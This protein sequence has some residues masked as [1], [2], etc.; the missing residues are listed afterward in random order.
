M[1]EAIFEFNSRRGL[2]AVRR[3]LDTC[4]WEQSFC[5]LKTG[6]HLVRFVPGG[7]AAIVFRDRFGDLGGTSPGILLASGAAGGVC[8]LTRQNPSWLRR[9]L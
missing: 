2:D 4:A 5:P 3:E 6:R 9:S 7:V 1:G 8:V